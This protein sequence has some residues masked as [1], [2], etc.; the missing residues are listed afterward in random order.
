MT[1]AERTSTLERLIRTIEQIVATRATPKDTARAVAEALR[2][3]L[4]DPDL[5]TP[6]QQEPAPDRY[7]QH[8]LY[9][10][11]DGAFSIVSLV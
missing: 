10:A 1:T 3:F 9:V 2:P 8:V 5:L 4:G 6:A 11:P 7:R